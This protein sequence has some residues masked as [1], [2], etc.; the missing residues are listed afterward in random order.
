MVNFMATKIITVERNNFLFLK[1]FNI[2]EI[3]FDVEILFANSRLD[4]GDQHCPT[5]TTADYNAQQMIQG[6][7]HKSF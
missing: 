2:D 7:I 3:L 6:I 1:S 4:A 5:K